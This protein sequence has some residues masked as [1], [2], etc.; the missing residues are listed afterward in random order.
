MDNEKKNIINNID[1]Y[2]NSMVKETSQQHYKPFFTLYIKNRA[3]FNPLRY[4]LGIHKFVWFEK[5]KQP[6]VYKNAFE[7]T[8]SLIDLD[9]KDIKITKN[10]NLDCKQL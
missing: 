1:A 3:W 6:K 5:H 9:T 10:G 7:Y 2:V 4:I 8:A